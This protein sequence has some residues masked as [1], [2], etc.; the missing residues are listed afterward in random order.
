MALLLF[1]K[2][3][4]MILYKQVYIYINALHAMKVVRQASKC[5]CG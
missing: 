5:P 4:G 2:H 1:E 3:I